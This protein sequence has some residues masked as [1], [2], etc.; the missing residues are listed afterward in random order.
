MLRR[1][2]SAASPITTLSSWSAGAWEREEKGGISSDAV[3]GI[4]SRAPEHFRDKGKTEPVTQRW[5]TR[6]RDFWC[7]MN[8]RTPRSGDIP[9]ADHGLRRRR[10]N[11]W[12]GGGAAC[13]HEENLALRAQVD[14][15]RNV[16]APCAHHESARL[17]KCGRFMGSE[18]E[19]EGQ[20]QRSR[21]APP[22]EGPLRSQ[23]R[24]EAGASAR[25]ETRLWQVNANGVLSSSLGLRAA[26]YP[27]AAPRIRANPERV[28]SRPARTAATPLG[29]AR[30]FRRTQGRR[31][32]VA[33]TL[34]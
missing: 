22:G 14:G 20:A 31:V 7:G 15:D 26:R 23:A 29:L 5:R 11:F 25:G 1:P 6:R 17:C 9:V 28:A 30:F 19:A 34:G 3:R 33:P 24:A 27:G 4:D 18:A 10:T 16:A 12:Q 8:Q 2:P 32:C 13:A 21:H